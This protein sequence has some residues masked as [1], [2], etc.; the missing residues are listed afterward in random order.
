MTTKPKTIPIPLRISENL[1]ELA[2]LHSIE[3][4]INRTDTFRRWLYYSAELYA[5]NLVS[6]GR[7]SIGKASE[8]LDVTYYDIYRI[9]EKHGIELGVE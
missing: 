1:I 7:L 8:L 3:E 4:R 5:V 9:A 2:E 6:E